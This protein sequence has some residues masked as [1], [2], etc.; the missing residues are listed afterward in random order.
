MFL[1]ASR[2]LPRAEV[3]LITSIMGRASAD[4]HSTRTRQAQTR[5]VKVGYYENHI[6]PVRYR[7]DGEELGN[8][9]ASS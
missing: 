1:R 9:S 8:G 3:V 6:L 2:F 5:Q 4:E 7:S